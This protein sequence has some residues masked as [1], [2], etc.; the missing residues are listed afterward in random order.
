MLINCECEYMGLQFLNPYKDTVFFPLFKF[1]GSGFRL[2]INLSKGLGCQAPDQFL[3]WTKFKTYQKSR[4]HLLSRR[5][6]QITLIWQNIQFL[7][8]IHHCQ[9]NYFIKC[10]FND[11]NDLT[12]ILQFQQYFCLCS[13]CVVEFVQFEECFNQSSF[14]PTV[15]DLGSYVH[16]TGKGWFKQV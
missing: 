9:E 12:I 3:Y 15:F 4:N 7:A 8:N 2:L 10:T 16:K 13:Y 14:K 6:C 5:C 11:F 1:Q